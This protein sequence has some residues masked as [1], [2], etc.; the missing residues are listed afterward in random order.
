MGKVLDVEYNKSDC[1]WRYN[2]SC[3]ADTDCSID[4]NMPCPYKKEE[5]PCVGCSVEG[6]NRESC[7]A[8]DIY[9]KVCKSSQMKG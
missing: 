4:C 9:S 3:V 5:S 1:D 2:A 6:C 8:L 7:V